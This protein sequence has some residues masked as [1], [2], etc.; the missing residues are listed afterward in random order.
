M[1]SELQRKLSDL[2][3]AAQHLQS[4]KVIVMPTDTV[5]GLAASVYQPDAVTKLYA[6]KHRER[7]P[8]TI[9]AASVAQLAEL[10]VALEYLDHVK[11]WWPNPLSV[12]VPAG[13]ELLYIHQGLDSFPVRIPK[14]E[15]MRTFLE[16]TG[17]LVTSSAN[18]PGQPESTTISEAWAYFGDGVDFYIDGGD[19]S[20]RAPSTIIRVHPGGTIEV[21]R[22]GAVK[23][24]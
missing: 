21:L 15:T 7:K 1:E 4:G 3:A 16:Q 10:G 12:V 20:G 24:S 19:L 6:L 11:Q 14:D 22:Q 13:E 8:G 9:I 23:I 18:Q 2:A 17:P 5:Y